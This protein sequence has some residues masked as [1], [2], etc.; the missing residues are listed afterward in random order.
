MA[1]LSFLRLPPVATEV[2]CGKTDEADEVILM[3][4]LFLT[5]ADPPEDVTSKLEKI[6]I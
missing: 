6:K 3:E 1:R 5:P 4:L 2:A